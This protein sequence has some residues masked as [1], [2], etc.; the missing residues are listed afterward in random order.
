MRSTH[1][2]DSYEATKDR[3]ES[4][5]VLKLRPRFRGVNS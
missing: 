5:T 4:A 2:K 3:D 1:L